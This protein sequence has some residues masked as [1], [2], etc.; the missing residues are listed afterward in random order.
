MIINQTYSVA[1]LLPTN[2]RIGPQAALSVP[3][4]CEIAL[5]VQKYPVQSFTLDYF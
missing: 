2:G 4:G 1:Q 5:Q 3:V